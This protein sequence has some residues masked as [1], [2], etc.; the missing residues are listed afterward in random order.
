MMKFVFFN[1]KS[2]SI[3]LLFWFSLCLNL[4]SSFHSILQGYQD[5]SVDRQVSP[6]LTP[7]LLMN[8]DVREPLCIKLLV[9]L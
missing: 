7:T 1:Y 9:V 2:L 5:I 8:F 6:C 4:V 3:K